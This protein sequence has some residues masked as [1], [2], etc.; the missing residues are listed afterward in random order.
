[1]RACV[2]EC[3]RSPPDEQAAGWFDGLEAQANGGLEWVGASE[4][5]E[6]LPYLTACLKETLRLKT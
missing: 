3:I 1:M 5:A 4:L 6:K 2:H